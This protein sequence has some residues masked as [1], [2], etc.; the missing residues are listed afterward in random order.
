M[1]DR[2]LQTGHFKKLIGPFGFWAKGKEVQRDFG[3]KRHND[4]PV[5]QD[6]T[7]GYQADSETLYGLYYGT[8]VGLQFASP[9]TYTPINVPTNLIGI[10][11]PKAKD[12]KTQD[13]VGQ[14]VDDQADEFPI[15]TNTYR[16]LGTS[17]RW[18][19]YS[20]KLGR[21]IW[22]AIPDDTVTDI[23]ID[24][25]TNE[26]NVV[27]DHIK[28]RYTGG[29]NTAKYAERKRRIGRDYIQTWWTG[30]DNV[31]KRELRNIRMKNPFGFIPIPFG[32]E[33]KENEWRGHS[34]FSRNLRLLR[35]IHEIQD[36]RDEI[37]AK[38]KPK[39]VQN[40]ADGNA[41]AWL[42]NNGYNDNVNN[43]DPFDDEFFINA[44][45]DESTQFLHL[46]ADATRQHTEAI[47]NSIQRVII[48]SGVPELFWPGL[49]TGNHA[50]TDT[51][52]DLGISYIY[53][54]RQEMNRAYT[55]LFNQTLTIKGFMEQTR[56]TEVK[57]EWDQFEL[58][59]KE[60]QAQIFQLFTQGLG[61]IIQNASMGYDDLKYFIDK[62]YPDI[63]ERTRN[64]LK[65][66]MFELLKDHTLQL[67]G[68]IY[69]VTDD[70]A[71]A[72]GESAGDDGKPDDS[73]D[74]DGDD[75]DDDAADMEGLGGK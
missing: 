18:C 48:G 68:D 29:Y 35:S 27:W 3:K 52:K 30:V 62:F 22:E 13:A 21:V 73:K 41:T 1:G 25:D 17:W 20:N 47:N 12:K 44:G 55:Q 58:V 26:I 5:N 63:P 69:D 67:K 33:C 15:I 24:L 36:N 75:L 50:S 28:I 8:D 6:M 60:V 57:N 54:Q 72:T 71:A 53:G 65:D 59:S 70:K 46:P 51:Q 45:S 74:A 31:E 56:Y 43:V 49:A 42:N 19:R 61:T 32:H 37:L 11:T 7:G 10:P 14:I 39:L 4:R 9:L 34:I 2:T 64:K 23:E 66:G 16:L 38:F 40:V